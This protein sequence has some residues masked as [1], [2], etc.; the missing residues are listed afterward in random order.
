MGTRRLLVGLLPVLVLAAETS[1]FGHSSDLRGAAAA[2]GAA[3]VLIVAIAAPAIHSLSGVLPGKL[4]LV[5]PDAGGEH[6]RARGVSESAVPL[7]RPPSPVTRETSETSSSS[8]VLDESEERLLRALGYEGTMDDDADGGLTE[9]EIAAFR[10]R[11]SATS[12]S[13]PVVR[14]KD[15]VAEPLSDIVT[16]WQTQQHA[17]G[18]GGSGGSSSP[19]LKPVAGVTP[20]ACAASTSPA[21]KPKVSKKPHGGKKHKGGRGGQP[22]AA[23]SPLAAGA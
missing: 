20:P 6:K 15:R 5:S 14:F 3:L 12:D 13:S 2:L 10:Q 23:S 7:K 18:R 4:R 16:R 1:A 22:H 21:S 9:A 19:C 8:E 17:D 11:N